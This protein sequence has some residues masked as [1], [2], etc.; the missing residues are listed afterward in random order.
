MHIS[1]LVCTCICVENFEEG[2]K[3]LISSH[4]CWRELKDQGRRETYFSLYNLPIDFKKKLD[5][6]ILILKYIHI[7]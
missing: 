7:N 5:V 3:K 1:M 6:F 2:I 4:L